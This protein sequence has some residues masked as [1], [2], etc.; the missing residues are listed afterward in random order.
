MKT[1]ILFSTLGAVLLLA[2]LPGNATAGSLTIDTGPSFV[3]PSSFTDN[4]IDAELLHNPGGLNGDVVRLYGDSMVSPSAEAPRILVGGTFSANSN[5][6]FSVVYDFTIN[7]N[8]PAPITLTVGAQTII[9]GVQHIFNTMVVITPG[10]GHYQGQISGPV[11]ALATSGTWNGHLYF[12]LSTPAAGDSTDNP[13]PGNLLVKLRAVDFQLVAV[14]EPST[15]LSLGVGL[16]L[17]GGLA[18]RRRQLT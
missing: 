8:T 13:D 7:L 15:V 11:F 14:P 2:V 10:I 18:L 12:N 9:A 4:T 1:R 3:P 17:I 16:A 6:L 5:D